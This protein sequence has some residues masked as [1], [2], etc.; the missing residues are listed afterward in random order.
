MQREL[1]THAQTRII[2]VITGDIADAVKSIQYRVAMDTEALGCFLRA[3]V[4]R[5]K[6][7]QGTDQI[8]VVL[9]VIGKQFAQ[10]LRVKVVQFRQPFGGEDQAVD[11]KIAE[12]RKVTGSVHAASQQKRLARLRMGTADPGDSVPDRAD[13][14]RDS[15]SST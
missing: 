8:G 11:A 12:Q 2:E 15:S 6:R 1:Q 7:V 4:R 13:P 14:D 10:R 9:S 5:E 3:P